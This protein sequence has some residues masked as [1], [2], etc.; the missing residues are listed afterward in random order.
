MK[1]LNGIRRT[2]GLL[3]LFVVLSAAP[4]FAGDELPARP[5]RWGWLDAIRHTIA[6]VIHVLDDGQMS[7]PPGSH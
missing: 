4:A 2:V 1:R 6:R 3:S 7:S 5:G